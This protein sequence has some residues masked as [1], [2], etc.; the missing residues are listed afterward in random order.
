MMPS[1]P[2]RTAYMRIP[3]RHATAIYAQAVAYCART[4]FSRICRP[5]P[6]MYSAKYSLTRALMT[7]AGTLTRSAVN[8]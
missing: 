6:I 3:I 8:T 4:M 1:A 7:E 5:T 2:K